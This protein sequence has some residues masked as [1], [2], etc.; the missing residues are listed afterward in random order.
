[1]LEVA[2]CD[3]DKEDLDKAAL[4]LDKILSEYQV[5]YQ[6]R[7]FLSANE[8]LNNNDKI[9]IGILDIS[10]EEL[11]GITLGRKL[12]EKNHDIKII[13]ITSYEEYM[14]QA[15]NKVHAFSFLCKPINEEEMKTQIMEILGK[16]KC[17]EIEKEFEILVYCIIEI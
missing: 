11:G 5:Q 9:D 15:I 4:M 17:P 10:M 16:E 3:D 6:I 8:L 14:A 1:M 12:K 2:I 13:Y 7:S